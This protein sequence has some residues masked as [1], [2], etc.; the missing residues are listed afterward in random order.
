MQAIVFHI[1]SA[2]KLNLDHISQFSP[3]YEAPKTWSDDGSISENYVMN[4][5]KLGWRVFNTHLLP[6]HLPRDDIIKC[7]YVIRNG[8]DVVTSFYHHLSNQVGDG[9]IETSFI[10]YL[11]D[12]CDGKMLYGGWVNHIEEWMAAIRESNCNCDRNFDQTPSS[13]I[14]LIKYE[15]LKS[16]LR[17]SLA[18]VAAFLG[19]QVTEERLNE[20]CEKLSFRTMKSEKRQYEPVSVKWRPGFEFLRKGEVGDS[21]CF[22]QDSECEDAPLSRKLFADMLRR[23][24]ASFEAVADPETETDTQFQ[25]KAVAIADGVRVPEWFA[26]LGVV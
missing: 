21:S 1:L 9:G 3:F 14:L 25:S 20:L 26:D 15:D 17:T 4:H 24:F 22:F 8:R 7:I 11:K 5:E 23:S 10:S 2:G 12:W 18:R 6:R 16:D 19:A 13:P